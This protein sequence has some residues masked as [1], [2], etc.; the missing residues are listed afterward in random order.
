MNFECVRKLALWTALLGPVLAGCSGESDGDGERAG[1]ATE[2]I[3]HDIC[4]ATMT[5]RDVRELLDGNLVVVGTYAAQ[6]RTAGQMAVGMAVTMGLNGIDF[7]DSKYEYHQG[8]G[9]YSYKSGETGWA[10]SVYWAKDEGGFKAGEKVTANL[11]DADSYVRNVR[12]DVAARKVR[13]EPGPLAFLVDGDVAFDADNPLAIK[14]RVRVRGD[15]LALELSS[16][17]RYGGSGE[18]KDDTF[19]W[20]IDTLR[21]TIPEILKQAQSGVGYGVTFQN[22]EY[23]SPHYGIAQDFGLSRV[24]IFADEEKRVHLEGTYDASLRVDRAG[25]SRAMWQRGFV[26]SRKENKTEYFCDAA[27][28]QRLGVATHALTLDRGSFVLDATGLRVDYGL[29]AF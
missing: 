18:G 20:H 27:R 11:F 16:V 22:S 28:T 26:S 24:M 29:G 13:W 9:T 14:A 6:G 25:V 21:A 7:T 4:G 12:F 17:G 2:E 8:D 15:L 23:R 19:L 5:Q 1:K 3:R 10:V